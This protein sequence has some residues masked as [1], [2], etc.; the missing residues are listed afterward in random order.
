MKLSFALLRQTALITTLFFLSAC[1]PKY[2]WREVRSDHANYVVAL[3]AKPT[4][5][6]RQIDLNGIPAAMTMVAVEIDN[7]TFAVGSAELGDATQAQVSAAAMKIALI[8]N[9]S[10]KIR[11]EKVL[12]MPQS[13]QATGT[14]AVTEIVATGPAAN[15]QTRI[16]FAR[17]LAKDKRV[18]QVLVT[19]PEQAIT[20][21]LVDTFF[22]SFK[23]N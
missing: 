10:G 22:L 19:G 16:L 2:D 21:D 13:T 4:S 12:T 14:V 11:Q 23:L 3:P 15:G 6:T 20:R 7:V 1:S 8:N 18:Y 5:V 17:F 9:I